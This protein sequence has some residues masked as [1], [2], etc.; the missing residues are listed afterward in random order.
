MYVDAPE[1]VL[2]ELFRVIKPGGVVYAIE[3]DWD[4]MTVNLDDRNL[5]RRLFQ[6]ICD[7]QM[8]SGWIGRELPGLFKKC[9]F[10]G[11]HVECATVI[12]APGAIG[13]TMKD[14][15]RQASRDGIFSKAEKNRWNMKVDAL[16]G[17]GDLFMTQSM[18]MVLG[19]KPS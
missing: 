5:V 15:A 2:T 18:I 11:I 19:R 17:S 3:P 12:L 4:T 16:Q 10:R 6:Y 8:A 7:K 1:K 9:G 14:F 13:E